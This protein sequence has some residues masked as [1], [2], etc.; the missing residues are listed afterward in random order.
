M[1]QKTVDIPD[2]DEVNPHQDELKTD[3][4][5]TSQTGNA[6]SMTVTID[7]DEDPL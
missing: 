5:K 4:L 7:L 2:A 3:V 1:P 6:V